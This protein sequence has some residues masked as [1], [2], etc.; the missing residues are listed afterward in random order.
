MK[1]VEG[2]LPGEL[3]GN[4]GMVYKTLNKTNQAGLTRKFYFTLDERQEKEM[5]QRN[6]NIGAIELANA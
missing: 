2:S 4:P 5:F 3:H 1:R 6:G